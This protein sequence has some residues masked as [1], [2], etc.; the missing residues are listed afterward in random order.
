[1]DINSYH[2]K[3]G[4]EEFENKKF[5]VVGCSWWQETLVQWAL[6]AKNLSKLCSDWWIV[7]KVQNHSHG[8]CII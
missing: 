4:Q 7:T 1:M 5:L 3:S 8:F 2:Q 6:K